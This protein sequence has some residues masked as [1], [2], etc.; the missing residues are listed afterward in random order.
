MPLSTHK[1]RRY[2]VETYTPAW[3]KR[4]LR[5]QQYLEHIFQNRIVKVHHVG[6]TSIPN[7]AAKPIIDVLIIV[8]N[9]SKLEDIQTTLKADG[10][11]ILEDFVWE[12]S[13]IAA[14]ERNEV[15][16]ENIHILPLNHPHHS[17][18]LRTKQFFLNHP[19]VVKEYSA[20]KLKLATR[21]PQDYAAYRKFKDAYLASLT[22]QFIK[23]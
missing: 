14:K 17:E 22:K 6:S 23:P 12:N 18:M 4:Y 3:A 21:Y 5:I 10:Y 15:R 1:N 20:L 19:E 9:L 8:D 13:L 2:T 7:M 16:L 11:F